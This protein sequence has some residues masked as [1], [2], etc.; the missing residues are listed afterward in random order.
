MT[1]AFRQRFL[2]EL[3]R[4]GLHLEYNLSIYLSPNTHLLGVP[5]A[6]N[7]MGRLFSRADHWRQLDH[8]VVLDH[9]TTCVKND[10]SYFEQSSYYHVY[11]LD[12]HTAM[13]FQE[14]RNSSLQ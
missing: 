9:M 14:W 2:A 3:N 8:E 6:L 13:Y 1:A 11:A 7:A 4:H 5:V 12:I 10:G